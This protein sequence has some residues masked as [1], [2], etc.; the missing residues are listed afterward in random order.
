MRIPDTPPRRL[1]RPKRR[2]I[3]GIGLLSAF[4][5]PAVASA[6]VV[7]I[8]YSF[9]LPFWVFLVG[10]SLAVFVSAPAAGLAVRAGA[11]DWTSRNF[12][13]LQRIHLGRIS[14][15]LGIF[16]LVDALAGGLFGSHEFFANPEPDLIWVDFWVGLGIVSSLLGNLWDFASP[17][18]AAGRALERTLSRRNVQTRPYP[19]R[20][21]VWPSVLLLLAWSWA[22]LIWTNATNPRYLFAIILTYCALQIVGMAIFGT[23]IWLARAELFTCVARTFA[24]FAPIELYVTEPAGVCRA[25]RCD[26]DSAERIGC[27]SCW[28]D[29][30]PDNRGLRLRAYGSGIRREPAIGPGG[31]AFVIALLATVVFDG[32]KSTLRYESVQNA[33]N[34]GAGSYNSLGTVMLILVVG[35]FTLA[36]IGVCAITARSESGGLRG[37]IR[38]YTPTIIPIAAVY[39]VAHYFVYFLLIGQTS[40]G[41][42]LD[43]FERE[44]VPDYTPWFTV[45]ASVIWFV[46]LALIVGGH[47]VA[48]LEA[49]RVSLARHGRPRQ[50]LVAQAPLVLLMVG[51][52]FVGLWVLG[53]AFSTSG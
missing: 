2:L 31:S 8:D 34:W 20:F 29:A 13:G 46:E 5:A 7:N 17:L 14:L 45:P 11:R 15:V 22:E 51:Y 36:Y 50:A 43:P 18:S 30:A 21:G 27:P 47:I 19:K 28:L 41:N 53:Q 26:H 23:E 33:L 12:G 10:G 9:P 38:T 42:F 35:G 1:A 48:V 37:A 16:M 32:F 49:H 6:H 4:V 25:E 52:T 39:F 40:L 24:R 44:W 3:L